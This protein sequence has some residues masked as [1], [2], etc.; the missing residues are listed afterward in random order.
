MT[1]PQN[2][3]QPYIPPVSAASAP[4]TYAQQAYTGQAPYAGGQPMAPQQ[5]YDPAAQAAPQQ[6]A[7]AQTAD[8]F[9]PNLFSAT[10]DFAAK[11]GQIVMIVGTIAYVLG[12]F[13]SAYNAGDNYDGYSAGEFFMDLIIG[14]PSV[15]VSIFMLRL[16]IEVAAKV[17][18][19][20]SGAPRA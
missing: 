3:G 7:Q 8:S 13:Y 14:A 6:Y 17:G 5:P 18:G 16:V 9:F 4:G 12:W 19:P 20:G 11:Y 2:L 10:R 1:Q 15:M